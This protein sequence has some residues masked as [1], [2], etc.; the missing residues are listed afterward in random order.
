[1]R[2]QYNEEQ[3]L[4]ASLSARLRRAI[5]I[6]IGHL[7]NNHVYD[8][9]RVPSSAEIKDALNGRSSA[10]IRDLFGRFNEIE[11]TLDQLER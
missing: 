8:F 4:Q 11:K 6:E 1:M 10:D 9:V 5:S 7:Q 2:E 3:E